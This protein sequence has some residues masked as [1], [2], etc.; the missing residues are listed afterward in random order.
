M[1]YDETLRRLAGRRGVELP[2]A[3]HPEPLAGLDYPDELELENAALAEWWRSERLPGRPEALVPAPLP[4]GY[5]TSTKRRAQSSKR[6]LELGFPGIPRFAGAVAGSALDAP[7]HLELY[8]ILADQLSRPPAAPLLGVLNWVIVRG[9]SGRLS[10]VLNLRAFDASIVRAAKRLGEG[11]RDSARALMLYL[12]PTDSEYYL[13][14]K[15]PAKT[16]AFKR[17]FGPETIT[18]T[19][20]GVR[21]D[22]PAVS[23]SQVNGAMVPA[24]V[25][26]VRELLAPDSQHALLD[27]YCGSGLFALTVGR[28]AA[29]VTGVELDGPA[30][31]AARANARAQGR[32]GSVRF[33]AGQIDAELIED[34]LRPVDRAELMVLDPPRSGTAPGVVKALGAREPLRVVHLCCGIEELPRELTSWTKAGLR[35]ERIV[36]LDLFAG[37]TSLELAVLLTRPA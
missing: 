21:I 5:R 29:Q 3:Q 20:D 23:F 36:P 14:S 33:V 13:E 7:S 34:R 9:D 10:V 18:T 15:R 37:T 32:G 16:L 12:D 25:S 17:I 19:V 1:T 27:L 22:Q 4:R 2:G 30:I 24:L 26:T 8:R 6:G 28:D 35:V 11:L 31:E